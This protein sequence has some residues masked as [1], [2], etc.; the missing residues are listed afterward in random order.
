MKTK[1]SIL[2]CL[3][4]MPVSYLAAQQPIEPKQKATVTTQGD[5]IIILKGKG[6]MHIKV[7]ESQLEEDDMKEVQIYEGIY[8]E[9]VDADKRTFLDALPFIPKKKRYNSYEPHNSGLYIGFSRMAND[10]LSFDANQQANLDLSKSWE[11]GFNFLSVYHNFKKNPHWGL[12]LGVNWG[13][14]SFS[15]DGNRALLKTDGASILVKGDEETNYSKSRLR[16]FFFRLPVTLEW[17]QKLGNCKR[18][19]FNAGPE[20]E[21]RHGVKSFSQINGGKKQTIGK[22]MYVNPVGINLLTQ[23]GYDNLGLYLRYSTYGLFQKDKGIE[24]SPYSFGIAWYL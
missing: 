5:S 23:V 4:A 14:R 11:F 18:I 16:H 6:D 19:F 22:G 12:N 24:V 15:I 13:Y 8:L 21:I 1:T 9:K 20:F 17:Q 7:Y 2:I 3:L 10:F